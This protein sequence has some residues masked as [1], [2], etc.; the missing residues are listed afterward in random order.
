MEIR[1][2]VYIKCMFILISAVYRG[3]IISYIVSIELGLNFPRH[4][5]VRKKTYSQIK[6][7]NEPINIQRRREGNIDSS[8]SNLSQ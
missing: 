7:L 8:S 6:R 1:G 5:D 2:S 4:T 3:L